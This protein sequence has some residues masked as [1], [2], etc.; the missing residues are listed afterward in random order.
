MLDPFAPTP[1]TLTVR[2]DGPSAHVATDAGTSLAD[3]AAIWWRLK[4]TT[5]LPSLGAGADPVSADFVRREWLHAVESLEHLLPHARWINPRQAHRRAQHKPLQL[6]TAAREGFAIPDTL[7]TN[8]SRRA[9]A[10]LDALAG[11]G[12]YKPLTYFMRPPDHLLFTCA[13]T[14]S[15]VTDQRRALRIAPGIFQPRIAKDHELRVTVVGSEVFAVRIESQASPA[16]RLDWRR[17]QNAVRYERIDL[18]EDV[19]RQILRLHRAL[20]LIFAAYDLIVTLE[21]ELVFLEANPGGQWLWLEDLLDLPI[22]AAM[23]AALQEHQ[24]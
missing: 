6:A 10:W 5:H 24:L 21:G 8:D 1:S 20:G 14:A 18:T 7:I 2:I 17:G 12:V 22:S 11:E 13:V 16:A 3:I 23:A 9:G 15:T 19:A 4:P